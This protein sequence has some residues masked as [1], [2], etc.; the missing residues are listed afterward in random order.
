[1]KAADLK[2]ADPLENNLLRLAGMVSILT[3]SGLPIMDAIPY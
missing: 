2:N 3:V 1:L